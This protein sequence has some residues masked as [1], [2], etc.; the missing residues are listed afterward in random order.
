[1]AGPAGLAQHEGKGPCHKAQAKKNQQK[2]TRALFDIGLKKARDVPASVPPTGGLSLRNS[3]KGPP[4][5]VVGQMHHQIQ[6]HDHEVEPG[7]WQACWGCKR[8][9]E[10]MTE[11]KEA[12][13]RM[14]LMIPL[15]KEGDEISS[16]N[17]EQAMGECMGRDKDAIWELINPDLD[18]FL[19]FGRPAS[20]IQF[21]PHRGNMGMTGFRGYLTHLIEE[22]GVGGVMLEGKVER[23]ID[24]INKTYVLLPALQRDINNVPEQNIK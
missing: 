11:L 23:L 3:L 10:L 15:G 24:A 7:G 6:E 8:G 2:K 16:Y 14:G 4:L 19:G 13:D 20:E 12:E 18:R 21:L 22:G 5:I 1:M 17:V 9:W